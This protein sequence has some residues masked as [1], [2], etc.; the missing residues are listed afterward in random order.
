MTEYKRTS[1]T[2]PGYLHGLL[3]LTSNVWAT[4]FSGMQSC[5]VDLRMALAVPSL[6]VTPQMSLCVDAQSCPTLCNPMDC[7]PLGSSVHEILQARNT[8]VDCHFLLLGI[9]LT[10]GS[11]PCLLH[12]L[13][14][15]VGSLPLALSGKPQYIHV[16]L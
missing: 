2:M 4:S 11:N 16:N 10:Q 12:L 6:T 14:W 8:G 15:L 3:T 1:K 9:F 13:Y 5:P 7:S